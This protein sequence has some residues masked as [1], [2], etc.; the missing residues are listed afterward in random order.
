[1]NYFDTLDQR[2]VSSINFQHIVFKPYDALQI[3]NILTDRVTLAFLPGVISTE[4][5]ALCAAHAARDHGDTRKAL[6]LL[7]KAGEVAE[8]QNDLILTENHLFLAEHAITCNRIAQ[9]TED[10]P[11]HD[12]LVLIAMIKINNRNSNVSLATTTY[13]QICKEINE[14]PLN[15][16]TI[17]NKISEMEMLGFIKKKSKNTGRA[18]GIISKISFEDS[19]SVDLL[20]EV[21]YKDDRL[22]ELRDFEPILFGLK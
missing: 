2:V 20:I 19:V 11:L 17:S 3:E 1:M 21:L 8:E 18:G 22:V 13:Q 15:R 6:D 14:I 9:L 7:R 5:I 4:I 16:S 10:L 12:K